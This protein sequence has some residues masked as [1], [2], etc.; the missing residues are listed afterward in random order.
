MAKTQAKMMD[1]PDF[2]EEGE[3]L[4]Y[5]LVCRPF[6]LMQCLPPRR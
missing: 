3:N 4:L 2:Q 1:D 6:D 5:G